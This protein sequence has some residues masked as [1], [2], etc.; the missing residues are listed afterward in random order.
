MTLLTVVWFVCSFSLFGSFAR[1]CLH[2]SDGV[3]QEII[4]ILLT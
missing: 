2:A 4:I 1:C 3:S